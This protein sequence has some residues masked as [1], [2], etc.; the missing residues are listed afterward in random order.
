[1]WLARAEAK[2]VSGNEFLD[3]HQDLDRA[4]RI[5]LEVLNDLDVGKW[6]PSEAGH[7]RR[8]LLTIRSGGTR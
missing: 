1:L 8:S 5:K 2:G 7:S 3:A 6:Y 4:K